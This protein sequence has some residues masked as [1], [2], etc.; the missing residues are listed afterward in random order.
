M[1]IL[2][3]DDTVD[4]DTSSIVCLVC[5]LVQSEAEKSPGNDREKYVILLQ[6]HVTSIFVQ[7][8]IAGRVTEIMFRS[9]LLGVLSRWT[10]WI[11][12]TCPKGGKY[13]L[14]LQVEGVQSWVSLVILASIFPKLLDRTSFYERHRQNTYTLKYTITTD[15]YGKT[16]FNETRWLDTNCFGKEFTKT[17]GSCPTR[18][19]TR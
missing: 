7:R 18:K 1:I 3:I 5:S 19:G 9:L 16:A 17:V 13:S 10:C 8:D 2:L 12:Q 15:R 11:R 14:L 6:I 4:D